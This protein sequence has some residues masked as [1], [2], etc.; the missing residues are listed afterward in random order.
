MGGESEGTPLSIS[1]SQRSAADESFYEGRRCA[2]ASRWTQLSPD[3]IEALIRLM[4]I[5]RRNGAELET[6]EPDARPEAPGGQAQDERAVVRLPRRRDGASMTPE[7]D[8]HE[9][10][11]G[12]KPGPPLPRPPPPP[13]PRP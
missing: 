7:P 4:M 3:S 6:R 12:S 5:W 11:R 2:A 8:L 9:T 1:S 13:K 10:V